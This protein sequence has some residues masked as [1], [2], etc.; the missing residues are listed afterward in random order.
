MRS[1]PAITLFH[2]LPEI[3]Q[4]SSS[5]AV[6]ILLHAATLGLVCL[7][8]ISAP[9]VKAP[10]NAKHYAVRHLDLHTLEPQMQQTAGS[11]IEYPRLYSTAQGST[12]GGMPKAQPPVLRQVAKAAHGAQTL[13]QPDIPKHLTM[14]GNVSVP[15]VVIWNAAQSSAKTLLAPMP[16]KP[17]VANATPSIQLPNQEKNLADIALATSNLSAQAQ[18]VLSSNTSPVVL[19]GNQASPA[20]PLTTTR[21]S[22]QSTSAAVISL[23]DLH[24]TEGAVTLPPVNQIASSDSSG[25]LAPWQGKGSTESRY[26]TPA[27][28]ASE[29][30]AGQSSGNR[31]NPSD[32]APTATQAKTGFRQDNQPLTTPRS[33]TDSGQ[34]NQPS[35]AHITLPKNG[36]FGAIVIGSSME[37]T[38]PETAHLWSDRLAYTVYLHVGL[39]KNWILQYSLPRA[40]DA[41]SAGEMTRIE[42]PWPYNI[43]RPNIAPGTIDA[44]AVIVHGMINQAGRF[45]SLAIDFPPQF[46]QTQFVLG[47][48]AQW[49]FRPA[50]QNGHNIEVE[51]VLIIPNESE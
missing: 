10:A 51:V 16:E 9:Q 34:E 18:T 29:K 15:E 49:Q 26:V 23:S 44:D 5:F 28:K 13:L 2:E 32:H 38:Y 37:G 43:V 6:S 25:S 22:A 47:S 20:T 36:Q 48:L 17:P 24:M 11:R 14:T 40:N 50:R 45:E 4:P 46:A 35:V 12:P 27:G 39:A 1:Y 33:K 30:G 3:Y 21:G 19:P 31:A 7:G 42:A 41:A 8:I